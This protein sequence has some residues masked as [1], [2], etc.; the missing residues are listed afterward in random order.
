MKRARITVRG[1]L[2]Y[3]SARIRQTFDRALGGSK[4]PPNDKMNKILKQ[5]RAGIA[6]I[7][8]AWYALIAAVAIC[9]WTFVLGNIAFAL[10]F[11]GATFALTKFARKKWLPGVM[12][13]LVVMATLTVAYA[14]YIGALVL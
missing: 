8:I 7:M 3:F 13:I 1:H 6:P 5:D 10:G 9:G 12:A 4:T 2:S 14:W 11:T